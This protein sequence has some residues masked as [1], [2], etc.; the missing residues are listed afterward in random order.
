[1]IEIIWPFCCSDY[2]EHKLKMIK[3]LLSHEGLKEQESD[4]KAMDINTKVKFTQIVFNFQLYSE[5]F[6]M[7]DLHTILE[8]EK[9]LFDL[10]N[11]EF[12][13][14][15]A[16]G[17]R[18]KKLEVENVN[19]IDSIYNIGIELKENKVL[20]LHPYFDYTGNR[21]YQSIRYRNLLDMNYQVI[22]VYFQRQN[23]DYEKAFVKIAQ[24]VRNGQEEISII[25]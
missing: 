9:L 19:K 25:L 16:D 21:I 8:L 11:M 7:I 1:M 15:F 4:W 22:P 3:K 5:N 23:F 14:K 12:Y 6:D 20:D 17:L 2:S 13:R 18:L 10:Y 24:E